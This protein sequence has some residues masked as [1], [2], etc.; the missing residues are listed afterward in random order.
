MADETDE[1]WPKVDTPLGSGTWRKARQPDGTWGDWQEEP[2]HAVWVDMERVNRPLYY[3][4]LPGQ[5]ATPVPADVLVWGRWFEDRDK[6]RVVGSTRYRGYWVSTVFLG[7][8]QGWGGGQPI[9]WE[10]MV[11]SVRAR[12]HSRRLLQRHAAVRGKRSASTRAYMPRPRLH[13]WTNQYTSY[14]AALAGHGMAVRMVR[15]LYG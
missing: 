12:M 5:P 14:A 1:G 8:D 10:T 4:L 9:L 15:S 7:L 2:G 3:I 11:L 6:E 13:N